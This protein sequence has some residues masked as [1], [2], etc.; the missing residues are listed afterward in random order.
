M[1]RDATSSE[2]FPPAGR[3]T[4]A[5]VIAGGSLI[6]DCCAFQR[7]GGGSPIARRPGPLPRASV[8]ARVTRRPRH[9][10]APPPARI[11][12]LLAPARPPAVAPR[13]SPG[14]PPV[15]SRDARVRLPGGCPCPSAR[16]PP[17]TMFC[18][19]SGVTPTDPVISARTGHVFERSLITKA[20][21]VRPPP[22]SD[23]RRPRGARARPA[24]RAGCVRPRVSFVFPPYDRPFP[25][26]VA[27]GPAIAAPPSLRPSVHPSPPPK[28]LP[29][30]LHR[31][32][33]RRAR[34]ERTGDGR[35]PRD[36]AAPG[37]G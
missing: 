27:A 17:A 7:A 31:S 18:A 24:P 28:P 12:A 8:R 6:S 1:P 32:F 37:A 34:N 13:A 9:G 5:A 20:I 36:E 25:R 26:A 23:A 19:I 30:V 35:V 22:A 16:A 14:P 3:P 10:L 11:Q 21:Q 29:R 4:A 15:R 33:L 2:K